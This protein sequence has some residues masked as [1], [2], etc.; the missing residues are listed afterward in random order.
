MKIVIIGSGGQLGSDCCNILSSENE[1]IGCDLPRVDISS[2]ASVDDYLNETQPDVI[3]NC[4]AY[5]AVDKAEQNFH[6]ALWVNALGPRNLAVAAER[7]RHI[8]LGTGVV[9]LPYHHPFMVAQRIV[10]L[11]HLTRGRVMLA[12]T[13]SS[14]TSSRS[15]VIRWRVFTVPLYSRSMRASVT[16][17]TEIG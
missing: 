5:N 4:A 13:P 12:R 1:T 14:P 3:V 11:D 6:N 9:S 2:R 17:P 8:R 16:P 7:T 15:T 10:Q